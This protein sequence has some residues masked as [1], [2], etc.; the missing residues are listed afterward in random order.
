MSVRPEAVSFWVALALLNAL[1]F[2]PAY[3]L[4]FQT[5]AASP[6]SGLNGAID[7]GPWPSLW[8]AAAS[9]S[10]FHVSVEVLAI[11]AAWAF[12]APARGALGRVAVVTLYLVAFAYQVYEGIV[13]SLYG[14]PADFFAHYHLAR[15]GL[16]FLF[17]NLHLPVL[18][19]V[20]VTALLGGL[21]WAL[22]HLFGMLNG[23]CHTE[24]LGGA[25]RAIV[26]TFAALAIASTMAAQ[27]TLANGLPLTTST[28]L[29]V[30]RTVQRSLAS[31]SESQLFAGKS[32]RTANGL[33]QQRLRQ[34]PDVYVIFVESYGSVLLRRPDY[35]E[36]YVQILSELEPSLREAGWHVASAMSESPTWG[37]GSWMAYTT[38]L[39]GTRIESHPQYLELLSAYGDSGRPFPGLPKY[40]R[41]QGYTTL[42]LSPIA[43]ELSD[44]KWEQYRGFYSIDTW[45]RHRDFAFEGRQYGW[46]PAPPDQYVL[47][48]A[49]ANYIDTAAQPVFTMFV[50]QNSHFP[51]E[52]P[53]IV[54]DWQAL[55]ATTDL[56][57][58]ESE[59]ETSHQELRLNYIGAIEYELRM[60][61]RFI[62]DTAGEDGSNEDALFI[63]VG[64]HQPPRVSR[65]DDTFD[66]PVHVF[67][68]QEGTID[69]L[70]DRGFTSGMLAPDDQTQMGHQDIYAL[71]LD[72]LHDLA[73]Q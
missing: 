13:L 18:A 33:G 72:I 73:P 60:L 34:K 54:D 47:E 24:A 61:T 31:R 52:S 22:L 29:E 2:V 20:A 21:L 56:S 30:G 15:D 12:L 70:L 41:D 44:E 32:Y 10:A 1:L 17:E 6:L 7:R 42:W 27:P 25:S 59:E 68:R 67:S 53:D 50:T 65:R 36:Q 16:P 51:Y 69:L 55:A 5:A 26:A 57:I 4:D 38:A 40:L 71:A 39:F 19:F 46:G 43:K 11:G 9:L 14:Q 8:G 62:I 66:T 63:L 35:A 23:A 48:Y 3:I 64:D 45:L 49:R 28:Y 37:G 58:A